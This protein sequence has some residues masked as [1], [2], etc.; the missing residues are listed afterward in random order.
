MKQ[1]CFRKPISY[2]IT[3]KG[4]ADYLPIKISIS[5]ILEI[6]NFWVMDRDL[7]ASWAG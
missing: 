1:L 4:D 2:G 6:I 7:Q 5:Q 3:R